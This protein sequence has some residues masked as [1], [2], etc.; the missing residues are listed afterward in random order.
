MNPAKIAQ[1]ARLS[2]FTPP[3]AAEAAWQQKLC[4]LWPH[5]PGVSGAVHSTVPVV[6]VN[7]TADPT[8]PPA[9]V[10]AAPRTMPNAL[11]VTVPGG[12]HEIA[13]GGCLSAQ[14]IAFILAGK[15]ANRA[16][17]AACARTLGH[18]YPAFPP[19]P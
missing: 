18:D 7:G 4:A 1:Q 14:A 8:D 2:L 9:N 13:A 11:L 16:A 6:F 17:W 12:S 5:D 3:M 15:P 10:A 19:A